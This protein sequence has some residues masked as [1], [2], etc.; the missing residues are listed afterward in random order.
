MSDNNDELKTLIDNS[1]G[2]TRMLLFSL[3]KDITDLVNEKNNLTLQELTQKTEFITE[4][5]NRTRIAMNAN[6]GTVNTQMGNV[7]TR[8][9]DVVR[10]LS[11]T[12]QR[13]IGETQQTEQR[14]LGATQQTEANIQNRINELENRL[15]AKVK[16][17]FRSASKGIKKILS[18]V[19]KSN[20]V[21]IRKVQTRLEGLSVAIQQQNIN[22]INQRA[23][24]I[25]Q[26]INTS[27]ALN[28]ELNNETQEL[29]TDII[30]A[31]N[32]IIEA[33]SDIIQETTDIKE[34]INEL[35]T[36]VNESRDVLRYDLDSAISRMVNNQSRMLDGIMNRNNEPVR[37][38]PL[39][40]TQFLSRSEANRQLEEQMLE[41]DEATSST[42]VD[43]RFYNNN[44]VIQQFR[45]NPRNYDNVRGKLDTINNRRV[46]YNLAKEYVNSLSSTSGVV[47]IRGFEKNILNIENAFNISNQSIDNYI[48]PLITYERNRLLSQNPKIKARVN[49]RNNN[50]S[51]IDARKI[52][53]AG[54]QKNNITFGR[55]EIDSDKLDHQNLLVVFHNTSMNRVKYFPQK[56]VSNEM[57]DL[58]NY[59]C[60]KNKYN[61]K[62]FNLLEDDEKLLFKSMF[63]KSGLSK[64]LNV[65]VFDDETKQAKKDYDNLKEKY[66]IIEGEIGAGNDNPELT[67][68]FNNITKQ[69]KKQI[70]YMNKVGLLGLKE[71]NNLI[72][73]L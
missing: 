30:E 64:M 26:Q 4:A 53:G 66:Y 20:N 63:N 24:E 10:D 28:L 52:F 13:I 62:L 14:I 2:K 32:D 37:D 44:E 1:S 18:K 45:D 70:V 69:L 17:L 21:N 7:L 40:E 47:F 46:I 61:E 71:S 16:T 39:F 23:T 55:Y 31:T 22:L 25:L 3:S 68:E 12:E 27:R 60:S 57:K 54:L 42:A 9:N 34:Q 73:S 38:E 67:K 35:S 59:V 15:E 49:N 50:L 6:S 72:L 33:T 58:I 36:N 8:L 51:V 48:I 11:Q 56:K 19:N 43:P 29:I 65:K 41:P 5:I